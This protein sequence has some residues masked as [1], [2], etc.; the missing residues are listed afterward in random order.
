LAGWG[1][2]A[3]AAAQHLLDRAGAQMLES[4][5]GR[6]LLRQQRQPVQHVYAS[7]GG[8][9]GENSAVAEGLLY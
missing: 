4:G 5:D 7:I 9:C 6:R 8:K 3:G 1:L 2:D